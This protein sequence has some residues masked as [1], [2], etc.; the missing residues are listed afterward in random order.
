MLFG[1]PILYHNLNIQKIKLKDDSLD[2]LSAILADTNI[3]RIYHY[4]MQVFV[5]FLIQYYTLQKK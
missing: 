4:Q 5:F 1:Y 3:E 2:S